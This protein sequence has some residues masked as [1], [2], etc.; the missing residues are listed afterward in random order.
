MASRHFPKLSIIWLCLV[1]HLA[2]GMSAYPDDSSED[3]LR[4]LQAE[5]EHKLSFDCT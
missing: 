1:T 5:I 3:N 4:A 2:F